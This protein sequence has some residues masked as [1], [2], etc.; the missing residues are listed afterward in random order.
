MGAFTSPEAR[1]DRV[2]VHTGLSQSLSWSW[3]PGLGCFCEGKALSTGPS[4]HPRD[5]TDGQAFSK[6]AVKAVTSS[7][8]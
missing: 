3:V 1:R 6:V 4:G 7:I 8:T 2:R 5:R